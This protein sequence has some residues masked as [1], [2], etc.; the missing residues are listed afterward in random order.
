[1]NVRLEPINKDNYYKCID[2]PKLKYVASNAVSIAQ[3]Y[4]NEK[5]YPFCIF[6]GDTAVGFAM[7]K[8]VY[9]DEEDIDVYCMNR[10]YIA[11]GFQNKGCGRAA[12]KGLLQMIHERHACGEV[13]TSTHSENE[14]ALHLYESVGFQRTGEIADDE[15]VLVY[16]F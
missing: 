12:V 8:I 14:R 6:D 4:V 9:D 13:Y 2:M 15:V 7:Y 10:L 16:R 5:T 1:M 11:E 3:A